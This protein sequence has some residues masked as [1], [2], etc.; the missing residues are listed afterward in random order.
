[1]VAGVVD[2]L[3]RRY[4]RRRNWAQPPLPPVPEA[5]PYAD[6]SPWRCQDDH[7]EDHPDDGFESVRTK[8]VADGP[9]PY[10]R[11]AVDGGEHPRADPR[12]LESLKAADHDDDE[13]VA[14]LRDVD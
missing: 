1:M 7:Q 6:Q 13:D 10:P 14:R 3:H 11:I 5:F 9:H 8:P 4:P 2:H 12:A